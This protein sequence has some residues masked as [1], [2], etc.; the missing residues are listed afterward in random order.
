MLLGDHEKALEYLING[1]SEWPSGGEQWKRFL[2]YPWFDNYRQHPELI[3]AIDQYEQNKARIADEL[4]EMVNRP[5][6]QH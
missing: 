1:H 5:E 6:W 2:I 4:R 3:A